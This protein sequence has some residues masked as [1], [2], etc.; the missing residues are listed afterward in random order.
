MKALRTSWALLPVLAITACGGEP[1]SLDPQTGTVEEAV[2]GGPVPYRGVNLAGAEF[3]I[4]PNGNGAVPGTFGTNYIYPDSHYVNGYSAPSYYVGKGM[5]TF[6]LPFRWERLQPNRKQAFDSAELSRLTTTVNDLVGLGA[7]VVIDP[8][9]YAR[10]GTNLIGSGAVPNSDF[11]DFWSRLAQVFKGNSK[12]IFGL[13]NEPHDMST[14][15]WVGAAQAAIN[16]IRSAG[17]NNLILVPG[18]GWDGAGSWTQNWYGTPNGT[19]LLSITDPGNNY[20]FEVHNYLDDNSSGAGST[21][22]SNTIGSQRL[23]VFTNWLKAN[24]KRGFLG[25]FNAP[26]N[27]T[28]MQALD[29]MLKHIEA[30]ASV[31]LGWTYWAGGPWWGSDALDP[32]NGQDKPQMSVLSPHLA[33]GNTGGGTTSSSSSGGGT[34]SSSSSGGGG[35]GTCDAAPSTCSAKTYAAA[36]MSHSTGGSTCGGWN[37][38]S[39]GSVSTTHNFTGGTTMIAVYAQGQQALNV[40]PHMVV[41]VGGVKVGEASVSATSWTPYMFTYS[42]TAGTKDIQISFDNDAWDP[43]QG[44]DRNLLL[45]QVV[46]VGC[47]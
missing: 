6:R 19:A 1:A 2:L 17:A 13:M 40:W 45:Q 21:C 41:S 8:H 42:A 3:G 15:Q 33:W 44:Y 24:G 25:E 20:A 23:S 26:N 34:T 37:L 30:N 11:A 27:T 36:T 32:A 22:P 43:A 5:T 39:N 46:V 14:E 4:D 29:D 38:W 10:Y 47:N 16:A 7:V 28:C 9:N 18:N 12:V 35:T 31:W